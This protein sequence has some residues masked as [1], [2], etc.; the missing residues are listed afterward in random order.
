[1]KTLDLLKFGT[2]LSKKEQLTIRAG[3]SGCTWECTGN[4]CTL[5]CPRPEQ[6]FD[7]H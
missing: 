1:M 3:Q 6:T 7:K 2:P 4:T 5:T